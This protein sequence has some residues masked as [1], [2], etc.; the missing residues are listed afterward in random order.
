[1]CYSLQASQAWLGFRWVSDHKNMSFSSHIANCP[2][3][4]QKCFGVPFSHLPLS[5]SL[6][7]SSCS[8]SLLKKDPHSS[9]RSS[10]SMWVSL[11]FFSTGCFWT[12]FPPFA[13]LSFSVPSFFWGGHLI[14]PCF[15]LTQCCRAFPATRV[16]GHS[17]VSCAISFN[18]LHLEYILYRFSVGQ[19]HF[20]FPC[21]SSATLP[22]ILFLVNQRSIYHSLVKVIPSRQAYQAKSCILL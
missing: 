22:Q 1:M 4:R 13:Y 11:R 19:K 12:F 16:T 17:S 7:F 18:S 6:Y 15:Q 10:F 20:L 3:I 9:P 5:V 8:F 21:F 14:S 2:V